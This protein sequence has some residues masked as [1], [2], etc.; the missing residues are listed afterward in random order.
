MRSAPSAAPIAAGTAAAVNM[1]ERDWTRRKSITSCGPAMKPPHEASDFENVPM[2]RSTS[3]ST[4]NSS[5]AP[6]PRSPSTP[7]PCASSTIR[8]APCSRQSAGHVAAAARGRPPSRR[9]RRPRRARRRRRTRARSSIDSSLSSRLWRN[10][11]IRARDIDTA[12]RIEAWS[13]ES[14]M[15]VSPGRQQRA[16][17]AGVGQVAGREDE[18][19]LGA[20]PVGELAL[21]LEVE[22]HRAVQEARAGERRCRSARARRAP[23][24]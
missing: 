15:T 22:R 13:P 5:Q 20:H 10:G 6:A 3:S 18:R 2:R 11:R 24:P 8:R 12:S 21:E 1:N 16:D 19:V 9:R 23:R 7:T 17:R 4:P 14:Q